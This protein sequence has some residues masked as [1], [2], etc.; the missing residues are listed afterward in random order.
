M[1]Y[2]LQIIDRE[3]FKL[4]QTRT[5]L[6]YSVHIFQL[7]LTTFRAEGRFLANVSLL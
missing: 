2:E 3:Y 6:T 4:T 7:L 1:I 5:Q